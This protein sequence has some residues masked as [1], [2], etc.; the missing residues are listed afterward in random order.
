MPKTLLVESDGKDFKITIPDNAKVTFGPWSP[1]KKNGLYESR[2]H[3]TG[4]LRIY[5]G[6]KDNIIACFAGVTTF[7]D[8]SMEYMEKVA[9]EEGAKVWKSDQKGYVREEKVSV[10]QEWQKPQL[11]EGKSKR[12]KK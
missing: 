9:V 12:K 1:P 5:Q 2:E 4:T 8:L 7:R 6:T 10:Q 11:T 3:P